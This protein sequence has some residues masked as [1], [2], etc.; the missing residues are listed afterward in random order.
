MG[1]QRKSKTY[2]EF[3]EKFRPKHTTD[4]C[5]TPANVYEVVRDWAVR[6]Y[7]IT[8][9]IVRPFWPGKDYTKAEY[10]DGCCVID[11]PPFSICKKIVDWYN[12]NG[13]RFFL[14]CPGL[15]SLSYARD[16]K[17]TFVSCGNS[18]T[19]ANGAK[20][21]LGFVTNMGGDVLCE[22]ASDLHDLLDAANDEN[23]KAHKKH[24]TKY[25]HA[26]NVLT[27]ARL[28]YLTVH[29]TPFKV[30]RKSAAFVGKL[31]LGLELFGGGFFLARSLMLA[32]AERAAAERAAA[33][34]AAAE[35][36]AAE[37][38]AAHVIELSDREKAIIKELG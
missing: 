16:G 33:E 5:F 37:R 18:I 21:N 29:H 26:D 31:D 24:V 34:R 4:D 13:V 38:A 14:F 11:N 25:I 23:V 15:S 8:G 28:E 36:A 12:A 1:T 6:K 35:R 7:R 2:E 9:E 32:A 22:T 27:A 19:F 3:V 17:T 30:M 20:V 10:P